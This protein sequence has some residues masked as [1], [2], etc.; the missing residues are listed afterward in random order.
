MTLQPAL[1]CPHDKV[2]S[3]FKF[4]DFPESVS[5]AITGASGNLDYT[6][7][8]KTIV[9]DAFAAK[10]AA[11]QMEIQVHKQQGFHQKPLGT[12]TVP[13][14]EVLACFASANGVRLAA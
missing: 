10:L 3:S 7:R 6:L 5:K 13:L 1:L 12:A 9:D 8:L 4:L 14:A 2:Y 11:K